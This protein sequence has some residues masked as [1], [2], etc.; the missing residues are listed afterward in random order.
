MSRRAL[1][2][3]LAGSL[4]GC[5]TPFTVIEHPLAVDRL[6]PAPSRPRSPR[7]EVQETAASEQAEESRYWSAYAFLDPAHLVELWGSNPRADYLLISAR[8]TLPT[9]RDPI[10][11]EF[12]LYTVER[13]TI[14]AHA[15]VDLLYRFPVAIDARDQVSIT[16]E[17]K[18]L[19]GKRALDITRKILAQGESIAAPFLG[20]YPLA[21]EILGSAKTLVDEL[22][23]EAASPNSFRFSLQP[24]D[25]VG[26][27]LK[28]YLL[29]AHPRRGGKGGAAPKLDD[30]VECDDRAGALCR[31]AAAAAAA[32]EA[33][34]GPG[35][36]VLPILGAPAPRG[37][38][39]PPALYS[40]D[41]VRDLAY[42]TLR[43]EP[44]LS[45]LDPL[46]LIHAGALSCPAI[47]RRSIDAARD[48]LEIY[49]HTYSPQDV[50]AARYAHDLAESIVRAREL[51]GE[52]RYGDMLDLLSARGDAVQ[53]LRPPVSESILVHIEEL[54]RCHDEIWGETSPGREIRAAWRLF[55]PDARGG[56]LPYTKGGST[57][58]AAPAG[59]GPPVSERDRLA[60]IA[61]LLGS[62]AALKGVDY[63]PG[64]PRSWEGE[65]GSLLAALRG[66]ALVLS[67]RMS[68]AT[69]AMIAS[70]GS[71]LCAAERL[72]VALT[73]EV[74]TYCRG[75]VD[76]L[77]QLC[78]RAG[79][80][81]DAV[82][83]KARDYERRGLHPAEASEPIVE[84]RAM[85]VDGDELEVRRP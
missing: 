4:A 48:H 30:V 80:P 29:Q 10:T 22:V 60:A 44:G 21:T 28:V 38:R 19:K 52:R 73:R 66:E 23:E 14:S 35:G 17:I 53:T 75:C 5:A 84:T 36:E 59:D 55:R 31:V 20:N 79:V 37:R 57:A 16:I 49:K 13:G 11:R 45:L 7:M 42:L 39:G 18:Y 33:P 8:A 56:S 74:T 2:V 68:A 76:R 54:G 3:A 63:D 64:D 58:A 71:K 34:R 32:D 6:A 40:R 72:H 70:E 46:L 9:Y 41:H 61:E 1:A 69:E 78:G 82:A 43:F 25:F 65:G 12:P 26:R 67:Q 50:S 47:D 83:R 85:R 27:S 77:R 15:G 62:I 24:G 81:F 51:A